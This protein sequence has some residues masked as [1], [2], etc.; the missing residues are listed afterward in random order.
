M[1]PYTSQPL[2]YQTA[3][4]SSP[5]AFTLP[6][7]ARVLFLF[8]STILSLAS[9]PPH[10]TFSHLFSC[11][12]SPNYV[13]LA[14]ILDPSSFLLLSLPLSTLVGAHLSRR[15][16]S[17]SSRFTLPSPHSPAISSDSHSSPLLLLTL[18]TNKDKNL[19]ANSLPP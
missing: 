6:F 10:I 19:L 7:L 5:F 9:S 8:A 18:L 4:S 3:R 17:P 12:H 2:F 1:L 15:P 16:V 13:H 14:F 11:T